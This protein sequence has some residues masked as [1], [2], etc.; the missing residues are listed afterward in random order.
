MDIRKFENVLLVDAYNKDF[1]I[2][3]HLKNSKL[4][5]L[6]FD[7][8][9]NQDKVGSVYTGKVINIVQPLSAYFVD[10]G[11]GK[12]GFL[13]FTS[14]SRNLNKDEMVV[15][16]VVKN[17]KE[18]KGAKL[19]AMIKLNLGSSVLAA[20]SLT[21]HI[22][23]KSNEVD[24]VEEVQ[25]RS[26]WQLI[27]DKAKSSQNPELLHREESVLSRILRRIDADTHIFVDGAQEF[28]KITKELENT[29]H[30]VEAYEEMLPIFSYFGV[31]N[32]VKNV[33]SRAVQLKSGGVV[34]IDIAEAMVSIDI[35]SSS[36]L[37]SSL[38]ETSLQVNLEA[39]VEIANQ[40][41]LRDL[42]GIIAIDFID[43]H[44]L[45]NIYKVEE[46]FRQAIKGDHASIRVSNINEFGVLLLSRQRSN[47]NIY[48]ILY[49]RCDSCIG[50]GFIRTVPSMVFEII[51]EIRLSIHA[52]PNNKIIT[53][54]CPKNVAEFI[55]NDLR[56][57]LYNLEKDDLRIKIV[58]NENLKNTFNIMPKGEFKFVKPEVKIILPEVPEEIINMPKIRYKQI[59]LRL[60][61]SYISLDGGGLLMSL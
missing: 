33:A 61:R 26:T 35:N 55:L 47:F 39:A 57:I 25:L 21:T 31:G 10:Y 50:Y 43:M 19:T 5:N 48:E 44:N 40:I 53:V 29:G 30:V 36:C 54:E 23:V 27:L 11:A 12:N 8:N 15:I 51:S 1:V 59:D 14:C 37:G 52:N 58:I 20:D 13:S 7:L 16:Q 18:N 60:S 42:S 34:A 56:N 6:Y 38:E 17:E 41:R 28:A 9:E 4:L 32:E 3:A 46:E 2:I 22:K 49:K 45:G 24:S